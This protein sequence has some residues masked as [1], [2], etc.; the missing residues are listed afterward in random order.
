MSL[1]SVENAPLT[2]LLIYSGRLLY[3]CQPLGVDICAV[4][5]QALPIFQQGQQTLQTAISQETV[6]V[7]VC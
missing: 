7:C 3:F 4:S 1:F 2:W 5:E 6:S